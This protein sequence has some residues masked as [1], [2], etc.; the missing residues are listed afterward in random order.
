MN[1]ISGAARLAGVIGWPVAHSLSPRLHGY[2]LEHY[3]IDGAYIPMPVAPKDFQ[4][5]LKALPKLGF[6]G[7]NLTVPHKE[8]ALALADTADDLARRLGAAN[9]L[10]I[11]ADGHIEAHNTDGYGFIE[12]LRDHEPGLNVDAAPV[13]VIGAGGSARAVVAALA[14]AGAP[15]IRVVNRTKER[16]DALKRDLGGPVTV[17]GWDARTGALEGAGLLVNTTTQ[18]MRG[19]PALELSLDALPEHARVTDLIYAPLDT[20][21]LVEAKARGYRTID[22]LGMLLHQAR[23]G[24]TAWFGVEPRIDAAL[25]R[26]VLAGLTK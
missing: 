23:P 1:A 20:P 15:E 11:R 14:D 9:T 24:F 3:K 18:G 4:G 13:V 6:A 26:H 25:R 10:I 2:W 22:G 8:A 7:V 21:L 16:A 17:I 5:A 12:N 19:Q